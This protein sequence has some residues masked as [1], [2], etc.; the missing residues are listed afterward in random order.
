M[1]VPAMI[2][3]TSPKTIRPSFFIIFHYS[4]LQRLQKMRTTRHEVASK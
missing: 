3:N 2:A 4:I 1:E